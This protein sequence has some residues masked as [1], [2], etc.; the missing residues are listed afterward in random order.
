[1]TTGL[2]PVWAFLRRAGSWL[3]DIWRYD[4]S[5]AS[6]KGWF[7][8]LGLM[9]AIWLVPIGIGVALARWLS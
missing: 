3:A 1:M 6:A 5:V 7:G 4:P 2:Q 9:A 8:L